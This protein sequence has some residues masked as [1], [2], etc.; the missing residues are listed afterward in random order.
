MGDMMLGQILL[1]RGQILEEHIHQAMKVQRASG[2]RI[3]DVLVKIGAVSRAQV[4]DALLYQ[5]SCRR[6][7]E[8]LGEPVGERLERPDVRGTGLKLVGE[9]L[10]G[11]ILIERRVITRRDLERA[12]QV[13]KSTGVR[14]GEALVKLGTATLEQIEQALRAQGHGRKFSGKPGGGSERA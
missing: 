12:L 6:V 3:G 11:E 14:V 10:L 2:M 5:A 4:S 13:Q 7:R 8:N 9:A 1:K